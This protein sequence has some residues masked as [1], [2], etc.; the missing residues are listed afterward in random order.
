MTQIP[1]DFPVIREFRTGP[2][3]GSYVTAST[4]NKQSSSGPIRAFVYPQRLQPPLD[5]CHLSPAEAPCALP[6]ELVFG[7]LSN[8]RHLRRGHRAGSTEDVHRAGPS[9][10]CIHGGNPLATDAS[11]QSITG[12]GSSRDSSYI[13]H[14]AKRSPKPQKT[15]P[16]PLAT[17]RAMF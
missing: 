7:V 5:L 1:A 3:S 6:N 17:A 2:E 15:V 13:S 8:G 4:A 12:T 11:L 10:K 16:M 14:F 9:R